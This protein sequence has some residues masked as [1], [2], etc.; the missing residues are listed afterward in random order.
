MERVY[1]Y[2]LM[3]EGMKAN[4]LMT[5]NMAMV[6]ILGLTADSI[7]DIGKMENKMVKQNTSLKMVT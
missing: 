4:I 7:K 3:V 1:I 6:S 2:G 5:R